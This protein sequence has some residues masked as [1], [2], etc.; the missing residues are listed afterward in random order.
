[1]PA[2]L[3]A[4]VGRARAELVG[5]DL[6]LVYPDG[7]GESKLTIKLIEKQLSVVGTGRNWN[8]AQKILAALEA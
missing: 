3:G 5:Q 2:L 1:L 8:T 4:I 7:I 6:F